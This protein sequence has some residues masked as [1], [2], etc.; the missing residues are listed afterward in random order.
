MVHRLV[1]QA[2]IENPDN[3]SEVDH[4]NRVK[5]D[6]RVEN[7]RWAT[8]N[9]QLENRDLSDYKNKQRKKL[10]YSNY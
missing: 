8:R 4:I 1:A 6:N 2:F 5:E 3:K 10:G 7:L 9:E